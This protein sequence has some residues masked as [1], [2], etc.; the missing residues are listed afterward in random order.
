MVERLSGVE[1]RL[2]ALEEQNGHLAQVEIDEV[3]RLVGHIGSEV[4]AH[5]AVPSGVVLLVELLLD[6]GGD[7]LLDVVLLQG[8][9]GAVNSVLLH[10]LAH[11]SVLDHRLAIRHLVSIRLSL[12]LFICA[13]ALGLPV[14]SVFVLFDFADSLWGSVYPALALLDANFF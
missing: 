6:E 10:L 11:V 8:L 7:V 9:G 2:T 13:K 14:Y 12:L 4:A 3:A 1:M 5:D